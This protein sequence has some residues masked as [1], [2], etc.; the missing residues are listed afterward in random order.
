MKRPSDTP[1]GKLPSSIIPDKDA[2][3]GFPALRE[4]FLAPAY[5]DGELREPGT[6][7]VRV[8]GFQWSF[9]LKET[10]SGRQLRVNADTWDAGIQMLEG[11]LK[12]KDAPWAVDPWST[13]KT[14]SKKK[15]GG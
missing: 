5:D 4:F 10:T 14:A 3:E 12:A 1:K 9:I 6:M 13:G 11:F 15:K 8:Y 7:I 2:F